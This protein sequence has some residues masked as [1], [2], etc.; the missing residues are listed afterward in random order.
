MAHIYPHI[1][2]KK[3]RGCTTNK[4]LVTNLFYSEKHELP[5][6]RKYIKDVGHEDM[7]Q[8]FLIQYIVYCFDFSTGNQCFQQ[9]IQ[10]SALLSLGSFIEPGSLKVEQQ[11]SKME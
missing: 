11:K 3:P 10:I 2:T 5:P 7:K 6:P 9:H 8:F 1:P 4:F